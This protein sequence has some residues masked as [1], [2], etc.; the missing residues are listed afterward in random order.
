MEGWDG[1][2]GPLRRAKTA[3]PWHRPSLPQNLL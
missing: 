3:R 2:K 1:V